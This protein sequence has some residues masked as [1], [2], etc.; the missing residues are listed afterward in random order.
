M[1]GDGLAGVAGDGIAAVAGGKL[2]IAT[3]GDGP[4]PV[5]AAGVKFELAGDRWGST[6]ALG[7]ELDVGMGLKPLILRPLSTGPVLQSL[8]RAWLAVVG[9]GGAAHSRRICTSQAVPLHTPL[10]PAE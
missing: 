7:V 5:S 10:R 9:S 2:V 8:R 6:G 3:A 1:G 4:A